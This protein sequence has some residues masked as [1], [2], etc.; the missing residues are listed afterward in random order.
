MGVVHYDFPYQYR[1]IIKN[2]Y[3]MAMNVSGFVFSI[4]PIA[5]SPGVSFTLAISNVSLSGMR[6]AYKVVIGTG[7]GIAL[8]AL[9]AG[10]GVSGFLADQPI[11]N[12]C[13]K[14]CRGAL[15]ILAG[16]KAD[17]CRSK[18]N[19]AKANREPV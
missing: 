12:Q 9:V 14:R 3:N 2:R 1:L 13:I 6:G 19:Q 15:L 5:L 11:Y 7:I 8:H 10:L 16:G 4:L 18:I 17:H